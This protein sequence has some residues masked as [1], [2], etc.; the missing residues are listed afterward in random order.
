[1]TG[2]QT[3]ALPISSHEDIGRVKIPKMVKNFTNKE[4]EFI[5][6]GGRDFPEDLSEY[7]LVIH[8]GACMINRK[9]MQSRIDES[10]LMNVPITNYG[11]IIAEITGILDKSLEIFK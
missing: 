4:V 8:C 7:A 2:V 11:L 1:M 10:K 3:C 9:L 6:Q 5:F